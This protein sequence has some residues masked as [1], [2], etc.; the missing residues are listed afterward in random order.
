M[1]NPN[2]M[3]HAIGR[4]LQDEELR[5]RLAQAAQQRA[6]EMFDPAKH[7]REVMRVYQKLLGNVA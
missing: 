3:A 7:A 5:Q 4:L 1:G 2:A 6:R